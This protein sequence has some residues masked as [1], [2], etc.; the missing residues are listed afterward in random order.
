[1]LAASAPIFRRVVRVSVSSESVKL[2]GL[3]ISLSLGAWW[4]RGE[5]RTF[6]YCRALIRTPEFGLRQLGLMVTGG[7]SGG[8]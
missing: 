2:G 1:M 5:E 4:I 3:N 6:L 8:W 7:D